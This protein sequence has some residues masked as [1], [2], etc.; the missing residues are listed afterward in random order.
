MTLPF[1]RYKENWNNVRCNTEGEKSNK[2][3]GRNHTILF[4]PLTATA[5]EY[6][7]CSYQFLHS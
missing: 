2:C 7:L 5:Q 4:V 6:L 1:F 3:C